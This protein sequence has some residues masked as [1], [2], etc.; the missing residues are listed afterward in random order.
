MRAYSEDLRRKIV[1]AIERRASKVG[2]DPLFGVSLSSVNRYPRIANRGDSLKPKNGGG[3]PPE[4]NETAEK[5]LEGEPLSD[6]TVRLL[7]KRLGFSRKI[8]AWGR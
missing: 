1:E 3:R 7:F 6:S 8:E 5:F 2:A 4:I